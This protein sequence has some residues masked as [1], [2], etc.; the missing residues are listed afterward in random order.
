ME[1]EKKPD[2]RESPCPWQYCSELIPSNTNASEAS[3]AWTLRKA[4]VAVAG[5]SLVGIGAVLVPMP[6]PAG[7]LVMA[8]GMGILGTEFPEAQRALDG[9]RDSLAAF[10]EDKTTSSD[11]DDRSDDGEN[12]EEKEKATSSDEWPMTAIEDAS[13]FAKQQARLLKE[14]VLQPLAGKTVAVYDEMIA[15]ISASEKDDADDT[16]KENAAESDDDALKMHKQVER[17]DISKAEQTLTS[18]MEDFAQSL[19]QQSSHFEESVWRPL[20]GNTSAVY[21]Q[22]VYAATSTSGN[23]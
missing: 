5:G 8:V 3:E 10:S 22:L 11:D 18:S 7:I 16:K 4:S 6:V 20:A 14:T 15:G 1:Q 13:C 9:A 19:R 21:D 2:S 23:D 17:K 12:S